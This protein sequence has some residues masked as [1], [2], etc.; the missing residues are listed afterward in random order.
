M[1][2]GVLP[3]LRAKC[4]VFIGHDSAPF[5]TSCLVFFR[6]FFHS[7]KV[8][9]L[10]QTNRRDVTRASRNPSRNPIEMPS[11]AS[12][13]TNP[14]HVTRPQL[15]TSAHDR[16]IMLRRVRV[17]PFAS[18]RRPLS[19]YAWGNADH[20]QLGLPEALLH[21]ESDTF[22]KTVPLPQPIPA[23]RNY[24]LI[25]VSAS[26][27]HTA[28]VRADGTL[29]T[30]GDAADGQLG[31]PDNHPRLQPAPVHAVPS[32]A[33]VAS[34]ARHTLALAHDG[35]VYAFGSNAHGQLGVAHLECPPLRSNT[36]LL[37]NRLL[38][39]GHR[40]VRVAAG[41]DFSVA[42]SDHG[43]VFTWGSCVA[44]RLGHG[45]TA[46]KSMLTFLIG[47]AASAEPSPR[48]VRSLE[49]VK[50]ANAFAGKH[51]TVVVDHA[52]NAYSWGSGRH[53]Q[54]GT[55]DEV[56]Q[57]EPVPAFQGL[58]VRKVSAG[59]MHSLVL[60]ENG[61]VFAVGQNEHGCLGLGY[62][63]SER[64]A[65]EGVR[66][67]GL[68]G[69]SDVSA[70]WHVSAAVEGGRV[71]M[72]GCGAAGAL[73]NGDVVDHWQPVDIRLRARKVVIGSAGTSVVSVM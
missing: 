47:E 50:I 30:C 63:S 10:V 61:T 48:L 15:V 20:G 23:L 33:A 62:E 54:L 1:S 7:S 53:Y 64:H 22:G 42:V 68:S 72:W 18:L 43:R 21:S 34:G 46:P 32:I 52:G 51:H 3:V 26:A 70:G 29:F 24:N 49:G 5:C 67:G 40:I 9:T 66:V 36:P 13:H 14:N 2:D 56:D 69:V 55:G 58:R 65:R 37:V 41:D 6:F 11:P 19:T 35:R 45:D 12:A 16:R 8:L 31:H 17:L 44:G 59:G 71:M 28:F 73:G 38:D 57:K 4:R 25:S 60:T 39:A 27:A